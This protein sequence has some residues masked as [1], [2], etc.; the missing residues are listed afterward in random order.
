[1]VIN[2]CIIYASI[3][4]SRPSHRHLWY[5]KVINRCIIYASIIS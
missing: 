3:I 1:M 4:S 5:F 2:R